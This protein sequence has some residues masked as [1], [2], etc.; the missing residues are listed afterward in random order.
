MEIA[1]ER[2]RPELIVCPI[3]KKIIP[4]SISSRHRCLIVHPGPVGDRG[5]SSLDW[6]IEL[7]MGEWGVTV[8]EATGEVDGGDIWGTRNFR[9]REAGKSSLYRHEVRRAA[10][11]SLLDAMAALEDP[12][13][14]A[15]PARLRRPGGGRPP[16]AADPPGRA[17]DRLDGRLDRDRS[18]AASAP[19]RATRACSTRSTAPSSTC[20]ASTASAACAARPGEIIAT[21]HGGICRATVD[22]AVWITHLKRPDHF[23]LPAVRALELA[24]IDAR[25]A[26]DR[27]AGP[28]ADPRRP[29]LARDRLHRAGRRRLPAS[30]TSTTAP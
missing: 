19:P 30:S 6:A 4:E 24:G 11:A 14:R 26:G 12:G 5:P 21:R 18:C 1:V 23:K 16:A 9:T 3:L 29:H 2:H 13:H 22:G 20:S 10:I 8:L 15:A 25:R 17:R 7:G 28:R 27:R